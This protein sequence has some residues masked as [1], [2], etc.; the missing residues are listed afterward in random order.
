V[1][2]AGAADVVCVDVGRAQL[3]AKL[4]AD[5]RVTNLEKVNAR[6][7]Q[8]HDLPR[9][10]Y[11]LIVMDLS[12][13]SLKV[14]FPAVWP[15]LRRGGRL[16]ALVK[17]Q[18]EAGKDEVDK[19]RG[20]IRSSKVRRATLEAVQTFAL[21]EL[22]GAELIGTIDSPIEGADGNR[23]FLLCLQKQT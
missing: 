3:H 12:F 7:L 20:V 9:S 11:D 10:E 1:L 14:V 13:I 22:R 2:Q 5:P 4:R 18:F 17:P 8:P 16:V 23:E 15:L 6:F 21:R 19:G